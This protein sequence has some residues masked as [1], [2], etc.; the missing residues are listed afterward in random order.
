MSKKKPSIKKLGYPLWFSILFYSLTVLLPIFLLFLEGL[1]APD[2]KL[3]V[4]FKV[5]FGVLGIGLVAWVLIKKLFIHRI[6]TKLIAKQVALEHDY[7]IDV[8]DPDKIKYL[9][10]NNQKLL[11]IFDFVSVV[12]YGGLIVVILLGVTSMLLKVKTLVLIV[13]ALY[14]IAYTIKYV[15]L[16]TRRDYDGP[17]E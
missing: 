3:G 2:T 5:S 7:S 12:L 6:E 9:W 16:I 4:T 15:V 10:Y 14:L 11:A 1:K 17:K 8:G 13:I